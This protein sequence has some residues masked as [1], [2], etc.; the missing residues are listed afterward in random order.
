MA[1]LVAGLMIV[2]AML[3]GQL[4][5]AGLLAWWI[6]S[7]HNRVARIIGEVFLVLSGW[8]SVVQIINRLSGYRVRSDLDINLLILAAIILGWIAGRNK[9]LRSM[10]TPVTDSQSPRLLLDRPIRSVGSLICVVCSAYYVLSGFVG[11]VMELALVSQLAG[12]W[13]LVIA[14]TIAPAT[15]L[16]APLYLGFRFDNWIP[17]FLCYGCVIAGLIGALF[18]SMVSQRNDRAGLA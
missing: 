17:A 5:V 8:L 18:G 9:R 13:G 12:F 11:F 14:L 15:F 4:A 3:I 16:A 7:W 10:S 6:A 1:T 2:L